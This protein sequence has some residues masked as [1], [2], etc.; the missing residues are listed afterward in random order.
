MK[1]AK[2]NNEVSESVF[3]VKQVCLGQD[4]AGADAG[5]WVHFIL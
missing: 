2:L 3:I 5:R 4:K 1:W